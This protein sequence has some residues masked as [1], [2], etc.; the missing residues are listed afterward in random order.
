MKTKVLVVIPSFSGGGAERNGI[1]FANHL[2]KNSSYSVHLLVFVPSG[3]L[4][5]LVRT[6]LYSYFK[7]PSKILFYS[8][9]C[10]L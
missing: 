8:C 3:P 7:S 6:C 2:S 5:P 10:F 1:H 4:E 9:I